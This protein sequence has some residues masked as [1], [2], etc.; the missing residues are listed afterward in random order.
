MS[1]W[2]T[3]EKLIDEVESDW[4]KRIDNCAQFDFQNKS[5]SK[6]DSYR[7]GIPELIDQ[8]YNSAWAQ[9]LKIYLSVQ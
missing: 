6:S 5:D 4:R 2:K 9:I 8:F 3:G 7:P 1:R